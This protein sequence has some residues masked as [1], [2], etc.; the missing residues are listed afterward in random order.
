VLERGHIESLGLRALVCL[1]DHD[2]IDAHATLGV[3]EECRDLP[4][5]VEWSLPCEGAL[6]HIGVHN[7]PRSRAA[8]LMRQLAAYTNAPDPKG[9]GALLESIAELPETLL[10]LNHPLWD[11]I[12]AGRE[13]HV[14]AAH[15]I[16]R[17]HGRF[18][19]AVEWNGLRSLHENR[20]VMELGRAFNKPVVSGGDR[21]GLEPGSVINLTNAATFAEF[22]EEVR[23]GHSRMFV[24]QSVLAPRPLRLLH[25]IADVFADLP[26]H[27]RGWTRW[28]DR[29]FYRLDDNR[30]RSFAELWTDGPPPVLKVLARAFRAARHESV[31]NA[32]RF[33]FTPGHQVLPS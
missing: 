8:G 33:T 29:M 16:L 4:L 9:P 12:G 13:R 27:A 18:I 3:L 28:T 6:L 7:L 15:S 10:V 30:I 20:L 2:N 21:H 19:H 5:S 23:N 31:L 17:N 25:T 32:I 24:A 22:A 26:D 14:S 11:E 1:T